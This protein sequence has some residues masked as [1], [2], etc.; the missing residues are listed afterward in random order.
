[1]TLDFALLI[2][3]LVAGLTLA[4]H[5]AQKMFGWFGGPGLATFTQL[6]GTH[7]RL[8]PAGWWAWMAGLSELGGG[9]LLALGFLSPLGSLGV[10]AAMI[11]ASISHWPRF[12]NPRV[13]EYPLLLGAVGLAVGFSGPGAYSL[14]NLFGLTLPA[15]ATFLAGLVLVVIGEVDA[16]ATRGPQ[17]AASPAAPAADQAR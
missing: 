5:G 15:P 2:L 8:R 9:L 1:M 12:F 17:A 7:L 13:I 16:L 6:T 10:V 3:R 11:M 14:D 4:A